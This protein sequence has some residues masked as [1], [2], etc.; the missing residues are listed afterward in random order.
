MNKDTLWKICCGA[1]IVVAILTFTPVI[2]PAGRYQPKLMGMPYTLWMGILQAIIL[3]VITYV[4]TRVH[5]G[6]KND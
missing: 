4:G 3:V 1:V 2:T 5:P 6:R